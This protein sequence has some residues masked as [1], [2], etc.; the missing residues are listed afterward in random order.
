MRKR[1][2]KQVP[3]GNGMVVY[4]LKLPPAMLKQIKDAARSG[5]E[6]SASSV[7]REILAG[8]SKE[9]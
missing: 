9:N 2:K 1:V 7:I 3:D 6:R 8:H 4:N 5:G